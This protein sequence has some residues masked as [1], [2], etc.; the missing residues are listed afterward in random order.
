MAAVD[1]SVIQAHGEVDITIV[2]P[3]RQDLYILCVWVW[4]FALIGGIRS[5]IPPCHIYYVVVFGGFVAFPCSER[6][7]GVG[8]I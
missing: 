1:V 2:R 5:P 4:Q 3:V 6:L 8:L 7:K